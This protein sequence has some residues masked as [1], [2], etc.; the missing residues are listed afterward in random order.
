MINAAAIAYM[1]AGNLA[2][3]IIDRFG[4]QALRVFGSHEEWMDHLRALA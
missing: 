4:G 3:D 2:H 1:R